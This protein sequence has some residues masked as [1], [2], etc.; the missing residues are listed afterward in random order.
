MKQFYHRRLPHWQPPGAI[1]F[2]T[3]RL[4]GS[5]PREAFEKLAEEKR[6]LEKEP[7]RPDESPSERTVRES[8]GLFALA[9]DAL[10]SNRGDPRWLARDNVAEIVLENLFFHSV[11]LFRL[12]AF[13]IM[14]NHVHVLAEPLGETENSNSKDKEFAA[15]AGISHALKSFTAHR[16]NEILRRTGAFWEAE[17]YDHWVRDE[18]EFARI[19]EYIEKN[20]VKAG[21]VKSP[22]QWRWSS[23]AFDRGEDGSCINQ[24]AE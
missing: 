14:P 7:S 17:S 10:D 24:R 22:E 2:L 5:L 1:I 21:L 23:A 20:P 3:Y 16:A 18:K 11:K 9:D 8:I 13:A 4:Y 15:L 19:V 6:R 12:W